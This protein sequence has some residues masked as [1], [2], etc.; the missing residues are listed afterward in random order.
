VKL[1]EKETNVDV[2]NKRLDVKKLENWIMQ[3]GEGGGGG[4]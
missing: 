2:V 1:T 4:G 3:A